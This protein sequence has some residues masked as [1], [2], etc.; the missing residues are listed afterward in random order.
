MMYS[1]FGIRDYCPDI[2]HFI[3]F[4]LLIAHITCRKI[5]QQGPGDG[6]TIWSHLPTLWPFWPEY[7]ASHRGEALDWWGIPV[8]D[9]RQ[10]VQN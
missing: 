9:L 2:Y 5:D 1:K 4:R 6:D 3:S 8:S 7:E 10:N